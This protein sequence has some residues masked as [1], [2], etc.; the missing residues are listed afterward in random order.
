MPSL[1][2]NEGGGGVGGGAG[3]TDTQTYVPL[4][5]KS[6]PSKNHHH[7]QISVKTTNLYSSSSSS[8]RHTPSSLSPASSSSERDP[9]R[10]P[11][12]PSAPRAGSG[13]VNDDRL[14]NGYLHPHRGLRSESEETLSPSRSQAQTQSRDRSGTIRASDPRSTTVLGGISGKGKGRAGVDYEGQWAYESHA[15]GGGEREGGEGDVGDYAATTR[16]RGYAT[17][18][19][20]TQR[21]GQGEGQGQGQVERDR[22][23]QWDEEQ[24]RPEEM[25]GYS[26]TGQY[27]PTNEEEQEEKRIQE[28]SLGSSLWCT[29]FRGEDRLLPCGGLEGEGREVEMAMWATDGHY[30]TSNESPCLPPMSLAL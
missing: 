8:A 23:R 21:L 22:R 15:Q 12:T 7:P 16:N 28:V 20:N 2:S 3:G 17:G 30:Q 1:P 14:N 4:D 19:S 5:D 26:S 25:Y 27:P 24:G 13:H 10:D 18:A 9:N 11:L 29:G 6:P